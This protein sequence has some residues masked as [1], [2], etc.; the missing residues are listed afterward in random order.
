MVP[1]TKTKTN[2]ALIYKI[3]SNKVGT[4]VGLTHEKYLSIRAKNHRAQFKRWKMGK[5]KKFCYSFKVLE[6][7][8]ATFTFL[9]S[10][11]YEGEW[12]GNDKLKKLLS[13][14]ELYWKNKLDALN[15]NVPGRTKAERDQT[16]YQCDCGLLLKYSSKWGHLASKMHKTRMAAKI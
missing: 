2:Y 4:Y 8:E 6:D 12:R 9:E 13:S 1:I 15:K 16:T 3:V 7:E 5:S 14:K 10:V 11:K